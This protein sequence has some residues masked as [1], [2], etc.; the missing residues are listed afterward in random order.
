MRIR[1][2]SAFAALLTISSCS[3]PVDN[4][5][6]TVVRD[7]SAELVAYARLVQRSEGDSMS[8]GA[9]AT[10][11]INSLGRY[12]VPVD[13]VRFNGISL[14]SQRADR[15]VYYYESVMPAGSRPFAGEPQRFDV[16][17]AG[18]GFGIDFADSIVG[19]R[20]SR[21]TAPEPGGLV[22]KSTDLSVR[23]TGRAEPT[24]TVTIILEILSTQGHERIT[25]ATLDDGE[26]VIDAA[27]L[28]RAA[29]H[30]ASIRLHRASRSS[31]SFGDAGGYDMHGFAET[32]L[33]ID[34]R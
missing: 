23:W 1:T 20:V 2:V 28:A 16:R 32:I 31:G 10:F 22:D 7:R 26:L 33:P 6:R 24:D 9:S 17:G 25:F 30:T 3:T 21:I 5:P 14:E 13:T 29:Q 27:T 8:Y 18:S 11:S 12:G 4:A 34:L 15:V 19:P